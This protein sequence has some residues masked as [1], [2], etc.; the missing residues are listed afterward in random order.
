MVTGLQLHDRVL[1]PR[2]QRLIERTF[3]AFAPRKRPTKRFLASFDPAQAAALADLAPRDLVGPRAPRTAWAGGSYSLV[4]EDLLYFTTTDGCLYYMPALIARCI[5]DYEAADLLVDSLEDW[6]RCY[7]FYLFSGS[8]ADWPRMIGE[9]GRSGRSE[10]CRHINSVR[11]WLMV[12]RRWRDRLAMMR[13]MTLAERDVLVAFYSY[14]EDT[15][16]Y[17]VY[18]VQSDRTLRS[19][20]ALLA[21][22]GLLD[23]LLLRS[24]DECIELVEVIRAL[25]R[26]FPHG[27]PARETAPI[28]S[29]LLDIAA[30]KRSPQETLGW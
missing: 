18:G 26:D 14:L 8:A 24:N 10:E 28:T 16:D 17:G 9:D 2:Q 4:D 1:S 23:V 30:G 13:Q 27:F 12:G 15:H 22:R 6:F 25:E 21:G 3:E 11:F 7:P 29:A 5:E 20:K 19:A